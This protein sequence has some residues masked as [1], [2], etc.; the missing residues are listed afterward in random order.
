MLLQEPLPLIFAGAQR[1]QAAI[2]PFRTLRQVTGCKIGNTL[3]V[4]ETAAATNL[5]PARLGLL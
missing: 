5:A 2:K 1:R 4:C 3:P